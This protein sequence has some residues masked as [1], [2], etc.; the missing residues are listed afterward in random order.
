MFVKK[1]KLSNYTKTL[2]N[3][4]GI[5]WS[6]KGNL[7]LRLADQSFPNEDK[8]LVISRHNLIDRFRRGECENATGIADDAND[9]SMNRRLIS[10]WTRKT[11]TVFVYYSRK[12][13]F[14]SWFVNGC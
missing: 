10:V 4:I 11:K 2:S 3:I 6:N 14:F 12:D 7:I 13:F 1:K 9:K 8:F 5:W